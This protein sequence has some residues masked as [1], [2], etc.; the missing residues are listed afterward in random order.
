LPVFLVMGIAFTR[1]QEEDTICHSVQIL[2]I[3]C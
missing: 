3:N 1:N 2:R